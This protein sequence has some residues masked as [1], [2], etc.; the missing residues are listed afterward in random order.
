MTFTFYDL[1]P[2]PVYFDDGLVGALMGRVGSQRVV[3]RLVINAETG[4][5]EFFAG[6]DIG[7]VTALACEALT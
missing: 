5:V 6:K 1:G 7:D 3:G 4:A 2:D